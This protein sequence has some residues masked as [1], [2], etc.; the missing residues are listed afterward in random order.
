MG[1]Q[2]DQETIMS[3]RAIC[4][5]AAIALLL[6]V[7]TTTKGDAQ[8][9]AGPFAALA[10]DWSGDGTITMSN[11]G[12]QRLRCRANYAVG[13]RGENVRLS[14]RCASDAFNFDLASE[15]ESRD[16]KLSGEWSEATR[17]ASGTITGQANGSRIEAQASSTGFSANLS[18][19]TKGNR[20]SVAIA[21]QGTDVEK[22]SLTLTR[23]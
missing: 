2:R 19:T 6:V 3:F 18:L 7:S 23:R 20:Q 13:Q 8:A 10:G 17:N 16:G 4:G 22:V 5:A 21:P 15:V 12:T 1:M 11:G 14:I 9:A